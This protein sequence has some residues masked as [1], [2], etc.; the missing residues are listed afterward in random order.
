MYAYHSKLA[1]VAIPVVLLASIACGI[2][3]VAPTPPPPP[4]T[5]TPESKAGSSLEA[6]KNATIQIEA[7]GSFIDPE[8]GL[9][10]NVA[11]RGSGFIIDES[12]IAVTNNHVVTGAALLKVWVGG[13][14]E[15]RNA[16]ILGVSE[17]SDLAVI[18]I[19]GNGY[20]YL[21]W[22]DGAITPGLDVYAAGFPLGDPEFTLTRGIVSKE[23]A[24]GETSWASVD[25]VIEHDATINPGNSGGPL[26]TQDGKVV[27]INYASDPNFNQY[28]AI[29][30][31]EALRVIER[32]RT[33]QDVDSIGVNGSAV[34]NDKDFSGI[35]VA[36]VKSGSPANNAG[37]KAGD[38]IVRLE[39]L[40]LAAD[41]TMAD[42]CD[43]LRSHSPEDTLSME[44]VRFAT[45]E[46]LEG[47]LNG[48][49]LEQS[50]SFAQELEQEVGS[51]TDA[52]TYTNYNTITDDS[53]AITMEVPQEWSDVTGSP[54]NW[55]EED[56]VVGVSVVASTNIDDF[57]ST[58]STP[59]VFF[60]ASTVLA[61]RY[62][63]ST[64]LDQISFSGDC[65]S[66][67]RFDYNDPLYTGLYDLYSNC[68]GAGS[69]VINLAAVPEDGSFIILLQVQAVSEADLDALD[70]IL[71]SFQAVG[72]LSAG[73][74][75]SSESGAGP[76]APTPAPSSDIP[77]E[78]FPP[79][80]KASV[81]LV[82]EA[83]ADLVFT[84]A[85]QEHKL[86]AHT[87]K[88]AIYDPGTYTYT[89]SD[90]RFDSQN[91]ACT[92]KADTIYYWYTDDSSWGT[93]AQ[94]WP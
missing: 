8:V 87:Q 25:A 72:D 20:P 94:I 56:E 57:Y 22:Y 86:V 76:E 59:G 78:W 43:I 52:V 17:C 34:N 13:E 24:S 41:G 42:Y 47:Q 39:G 53:G 89:A 64:L 84:M 2:G 62:D 45:Q 46:V 5:P 30:R 32:L 44:V 83:N 58:Y 6:V 50:F 79:A 15:P 1:R 16:K 48:R 40:V 68:G 61:Q 4:P 9:Q 10:L 77:A 51:G 70:R 27:G 66:E 74:S 92:L 33:G 49:E 73:G 67:G 88:V 54:W 18:D 91:A 63:T 93:C 81:V 80:G 11:G 3:T 7:Q 55:G 60:G 35:W 29:A 71:N 19:E 85:N 28:F 38:V 21:E 37:I 26:V 75:V 82:N 69:A 65:T 90:P 12:G 23:R 14:S 31:D 36:S